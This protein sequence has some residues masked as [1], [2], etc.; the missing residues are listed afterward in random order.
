MRRHKDE[1]IKIKRYG[2]VFSGKQVGEL[3]V[4][5]LPKNLDVRSVIDPMVGQGDLLQAAYAK[6]PQADMILGIDV[7][8]DVR[9]R[10]NDI[11][12]EAEILIKDAF[13][14]SE[15]DLEGGWDLVITNPP[16]IRYQHSKVTRR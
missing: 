9:I 5:M 12:P 16:Y 10:C 14:S 2:Q 13:K 7:D 6:Y 3:L 4:S 8:E 11:V 15:I 1:T